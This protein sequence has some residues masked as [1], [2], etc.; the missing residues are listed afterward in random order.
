MNRPLGPG[1]KEAKT[2]IYRKRLSD[3][4]DQDEE[5]GRFLERVGHTATGH[6]IK[7]FDSSVDLAGCVKQ[8]VAAWQTRVIRDRNLS[9]RRPT[10]PGD[11]MRRRLL[12]LLGK[13][14]KFWIEGVL[15]RS[16]HNTALIELGREESSDLVD[17][18][19][20]G[21]MEL[22]DQ[23]RRGMPTATKLLDVFEEAGRALLILGD[24][25]AGKTTTLLQL[26]RALATRAE[27]DATE[28][29]PVVFNLSS[30]G[31]SRP[32]LR[33][34]MVA[35]TNRQYQIPKGVAR[36]WIDGNHILPLLDGLDEVEEGARVEC[37]EAVNAF[38]EDSGLAGLIVC[39]RLDE[40]QGLP[41][42]LTLNAAVCL[43]PLALVQ[44]DLYLHQ[45]GPGSAGLRSQLE[46][47]QTLQILNEGIRLSLRT[48]SYCFLATI[49]LLSIV[50]A[51][52]GLGLGNGLLG[53]GLGAVG[54]LVLALPVS[55]W[56]GGFDVIQHYALRLELLRRRHMPL[57]YARFLDHASRIGIL[58]KVGS[59]YLFS[60]ARLRQHFE[61]MTPI[62]GSGAAPIRRQ[63]S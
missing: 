29:I 12:I 45:L 40:Y 8:D 51:A 33:D 11:E 24:P 31:L 62:A 61:A 14:R 16:L 58:Q 20:H 1:S 17:N 48:M 38:A 60:Q 18:P 27:R 28:P 50:G 26:A 44:A 22:P 43:Q 5:L 37:V 4:D 35:E 25:G 2:K 63:P 59:G 32:A 53:L 15:E 41:L 56:F 21:V 52:V 23:T 7:L 34:W 3:S 13:V 54:G 55:L 36:Q 47:D 42:R 30:W 57:R 10:L 19:W 49:G 6:T 46:A 39:S 9:V